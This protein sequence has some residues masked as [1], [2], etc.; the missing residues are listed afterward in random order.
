M[1]VMMMSD[2]V[3]GMVEYS[4]ATDALTVCSRTRSIIGS[5]T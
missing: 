4:A 5:S 3:G 1:L 2:V